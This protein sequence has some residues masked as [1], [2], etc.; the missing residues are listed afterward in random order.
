MA[1]QNPCVMIMA[2]GTGG[3][4][5]PALAVA[6]ELHDLNVRT[7]WLGS[8]HGLENR[9]VPEHGIKLVRILVSGLRGKGLS[10]WLVAPFVL[11][12]GLVQSVVALLSERPG[13]V[14]GMGG[15][16]SGPGGIAAWLCRTPLVIHEQNARPGSTNKILSRFAT[17]VFQAFPK[18]FASACALTV[19]NP[20]REEI[21]AL[22]RDRQSYVPN[23]SPRNTSFNLLILGGSRGARFLNTHVPEV[24]AALSRENPNLEISVRHQCGD[25]DLEKT[26]EFYQGLSGKIE[27]VAYIEDMAS[28]YAWSDLVICRAGAMTISELA[29]AG[30]ASILV[31]FP[32]ATDDHQTMNAMFLVEQGA[33]LIVPQSDSFTHELQDA[34][35]KLLGNKQRLE[36]MAAKAH[37]AAIYDAAKIVAQKCRE[38]ANA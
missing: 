26:R 19:G 14:L 22:S 2:G 35:L 5:Y 11:S 12:I 32:Y 34:L 37:S 7:V 38:L 30:R 9:I 23:D 24:V 10:K 15:F 25:N 20:V 31:P 36:D 28:S 18:T 13:A 16:A 17:Q 1:N 3:H 21:V 27:V 6:K 29:A 33:G 8:K 4:I